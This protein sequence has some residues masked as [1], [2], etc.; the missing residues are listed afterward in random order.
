MF[1]LINVTLNNIKFKL[2]FAEQGTTKEITAS[3]ISDFN[4][5]FPEFS[6]NRISNLFRRNLFKKNI[7]CSN[8]NYT[9]FCSDCVSIFIFD[10]I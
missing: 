7:F 3:E 6:Q 1:H 9:D 4:D 10:N 8:L 5:I 2:L